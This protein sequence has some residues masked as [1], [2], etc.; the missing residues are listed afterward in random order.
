MSGK[1]TW[2]EEL[3]ADALTRCSNLC[4]MLCSGMTRQEIAEVSGCSYAQIAATIAVLGIAPLAKHGGIGRNPVTDKDLQMY[5]CIARGDFLYDVARQ[6]NLTRAQASR[7]IARVYDMK[8]SSQKGLWAE[9]ALV[10]RLCIRTMNVL[11]TNGINSLDGFLELDKPT[12]MS[13]RH[14]GMRTWR[15]ISEVQKE[16]RHSGAKEGESI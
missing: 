10:S 3:V 5:N 13:M 14:A 15:E 2:K 8:K 16:V 6:F 1:K 9:E 11:E 4:Q 7:R 12:V